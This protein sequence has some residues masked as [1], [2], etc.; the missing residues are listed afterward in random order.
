M[1]SRSMQRRIVG[2]KIR[3]CS[4]QS[5]PRGRSLPEYVFGSYGVLCITYF[6]K[7][8]F[9]K[10]LGVLY[11]KIKQS[12]TNELGNIPTQRTNEI[13]LNWIHLKESNISLYSFT[14]YTKSVS[15]FLLR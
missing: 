2:H 9:C 3:Y 6:L 10:H 1:I 14:I 7:G 13:Q 11:A 15:V 12:Q 4:T 5:P 8:T